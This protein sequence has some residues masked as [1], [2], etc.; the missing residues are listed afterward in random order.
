MAAKES[1]EDQKSSIPKEMYVDKTAAR[2]PGKD[3][4]V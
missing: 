4:D 2:R 3:E 1:G